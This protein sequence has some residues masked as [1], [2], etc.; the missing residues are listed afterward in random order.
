MI[1][2]L[3]L[4]N[5]L[6]QKVDKEVEIGESIRW[7]GQPVPRFLTASSIGS[8]LFAIPWTAFAVF[9]MLMASTAS[10]LFALFG[11][12]FVLVGFG[13]LS[14]PIWL[15][16]SARNTA[17]LITNKRAISISIPVT[18][19][20]NILSTTIRSYPPSELKNIYRKERADGT[21]DVVM[22]VQQSTKYVNNRRNHT[23][24]EIGFMG[25]RNPQEVEKMLRQLAQ[26]D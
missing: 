1:N 10:I 19:F 26:D 4:P 6:R 21:G 22:A 7:I 12:P 3:Q 18:S 24:E 13:M 5:K 17:Y 25:I 23:T 16:L 9:W 15:R 2:K 8:F 14:S 20:G 11:I